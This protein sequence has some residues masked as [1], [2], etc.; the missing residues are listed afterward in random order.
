MAVYLPLVADALLNTPL[1]LHDKKAEVI[2][3]VLANRVNIASFERMAENGGRL[4]RGD[5]VDVAALARRNAIAGIPNLPQPVKT[6]DGWYGDRPYE[7]SPSGIAIIQIWGTLC[8][9]WGI[10][11]FSGM[12]GYDGIMTA[13]D[14]AQRDAQVKGIFLHVNSG[15][16]T[17]D[18]L[19]ECGRFIYQ[20]SARFGGK[21]IIGYAGDYAYSAAYWLL[22][23][24]DERYVGET[25]GVGSIG[26]ISL[27]ADISRM[28]DEDGVDVTVF[29]S[30]SGKAI[31]VGGIEPLPEGE[32][33]RIQ[34]QIEYLG[35]IFEKRVAEFIPTL[36]QS[37]VAA[38]N[39]LDYE[40]PRAKAIGLVN[41]VMSMPEAWA[42]LEQIVAR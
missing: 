25:G 8:R 40:G 10:G 37:A 27:Y 5:L 21:P 41:D 35:G 24:C 9:T 14:F 4:E 22:A 23:A 33:R 38:T 6:T 1:A 28:L 30:R 36:S 20:C 31:G 19:D 34:E 29:R 26:C 17:V 32:V 15:G 11:P 16:G 39:A 3:A 7:L 12:T 2:V 42:R 18:G 13:I